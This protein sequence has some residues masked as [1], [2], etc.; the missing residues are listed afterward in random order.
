[1]SKFWNAFLAGAGSGLAQGFFGQIVKSREDEKKR[2][3]REKEREQEHRYQENM[4]NIEWAS[5]R[6]EN[7]LTRRTQMEIERMRE[8]SLGPGRAAQAEAARAL[9]EK[10]RSSATGRPSP[11]SKEGKQVAD[12]NN[13]LSDPSTRAWADQLD[14][15]IRTD[16]YGAVGPSPFGARSMD[17]SGVGAEAPSGSR[18][19]LVPSAPDIPVSP[20][21]FR[22]SIDRQ[23]PREGIQL[24]QLPGNDMRDQLGVLE[25]KLRATGQH[26]AANE[27]QG[28]IQVLM[29]GPT[30]PG[31]QEAASRLEVIMQ[32]MGG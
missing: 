6:V 8:K 28:L 25:Q 18:S 19:R 13:F 32:A 30:D 31:Y 22:D 4:A 24:P 15:I 12:Y 17:T 20:N 10:Y 7:D 16:S 3:E 26:E 14:R 29:N 27:L 21:M 1:M 5:K 9:A 23:V 2:L 11:M